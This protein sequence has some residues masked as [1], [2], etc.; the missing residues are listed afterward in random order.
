MFKRILMLLVVASFAVA[1]GAAFAS[2]SSDPA[3]SGEVVHGG[4]GIGGHGGTV[5]EPVYDDM[6]GVL[7]Y[8]S[9]PRGAPDPVNSP[10]IAAAPFYLP[11]YPTG[12]LTGIT[13]NCQDIPAEN[14][15]DHGGP[16]AALAAA[17]ESGVY[18]GGV[19]GHDHLMAGPGSGGDFNIAWV[20]TLVLFTNSA[21]VTHITTLDQVNT[22]LG[23]GKVMEVKLDGSDPRAPFNLTFHCSVV[24]AAVY[25]NGI[26]WVVSN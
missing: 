13:L 8:V 18:G 25:A 14:C 1:V 3:P 5:V 6:T 2:A 7:K 9:T 20:P 23:A 22:L 10:P 17:F 4:T 21:Y 11:V 12:A 24:P 19:R 15:P 26:P 16:V